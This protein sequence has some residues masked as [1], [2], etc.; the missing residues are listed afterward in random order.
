MSDTKLPSIVVNPITGDNERAEVVIGE[1]HA[2]LVKHGYGLLHDRPNNVMVLGKMSTF[3]NECRVLAKIYRIVPDGAV[4]QR[5]DW[6][7]NPKIPPP[8]Q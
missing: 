8:K 5:M 6:L 2:V 1:L 4:W 7:N 3:G